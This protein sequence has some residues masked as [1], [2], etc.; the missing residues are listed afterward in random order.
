MEFGTRSL[1]VALITLYGIA[2]VEGQID[3]ARRELIQ[4]GYN[5]AFEGRAPISGYA[6]Y[7]NNAPY[8]HSTNLA[9]RLAVA[10]VYLDSELGIRSVLGPNTDLGLGL[11]G[12]GFADTYS[13]IRHG[14]YLKAESFTGHGAELSSSVYH[15]F[16]PG[17]RIPLYAVL[18]GAVHYS[19]YTDDSATADNFA[20]PEDQAT[21]RL[22]TGLRWGGH[23]PL[24]LTELAMELSVWYEGEHRT[25]AGTYGYR[26]ANSG[27]DRRVEGQSHRFWSRAMLAYTMPEWKHSFAVNLT[28][29]TTVNADRFSAYRLGGVLPLVSEF[30]LP[31]PGYYFQEISARTFILLA[32]NYTVP[33]DA[34]QRWSVSAM[35]A[36]AGVEYVD[37]L[38]QPG[39]WHSG[40]GG[41][42]IY[43]SPTDSWQVAVSYG[44]GIDAVR[45][46]H[47]GAHSLS[48]LLQFD[49]DSTKRR[50]FD[51]TENIGRSRGLESIMRNIFR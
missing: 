11:A 29:G 22:R 35:A 33:L 26:T 10:P 37:G 40:V 2:C 41:G 51:P 12:G 43:R 30:P 5:Q 49:L 21:F 39:Q 6:F 28:G 14:K 34:R 16:N 3:P 38:S 48:F 9:L 13:E 36:T 15:L 47:R 42:M 4:L 25:G 45:D 44:Y 32:G 7:Y 19:A 8:F 23:E 20:E 31:L 24:M 1:M 18:R 17:E 27:G 46:S 50:F